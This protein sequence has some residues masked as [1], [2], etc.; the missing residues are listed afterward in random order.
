M[1]RQSGEVACLSLGYLSSKYF[2][3]G[4]VLPYL[5]SFRANTWEGTRY[6]FKFVIFFCR[7]RADTPLNRRGANE[8]VD[9]LIFRVNWDDIF[10]RNALL[11][12]NTVIFSG[13]L[14]KFALRTTRYAVRMVIGNKTYPEC[15]KKCKEYLL[16]ICKIVSIE[17]RV[18]K[19]LFLKILKII[20]NNLE[21]FSFKGK[22]N[23]NPI[24]S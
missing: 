23:K 16:K 19:K 14:R 4:E 7:S 9:R 15:E 24:K 17:R 12:L 21:S 6:F 5:L 2:P 10:F 3:V 13:S 20:Y 11:A 8:F 22:K 18:L 1:H